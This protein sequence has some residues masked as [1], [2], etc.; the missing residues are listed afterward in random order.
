MVLFLPQAAK[1]NR[2]LFRSTRGAMLDMSFEE[3]WISLLLLPM[4][5]FFENPGAVNSIFEHATQGSSV[6]LV[7][8][9]PRPA[10]TLL[11]S[12]GRF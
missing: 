12:A 8:R 1:R 10:L 7:S 2:M 9:V 5:A 6:S 11:S 4:H 3:V